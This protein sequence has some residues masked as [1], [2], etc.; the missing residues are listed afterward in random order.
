MARNY[1]YLIAGLPELSFL[2][3]DSQTLTHDFDFLNI[4]DSILEEVSAKDALHVYDLLSDI[5][6]YNLITLIYGKKRQWKN[7]GQIEEQTL[8][9]LKNR[10]LPA[11]LAAFITYIEEYENENKAKPNELAAER[12]LYELWYDKLEASKNKFIAQ[13][14]RFDREIR[15]IKAAYAGRQ[16]ETSDNRL[17]KEDDD[18]TQSLLKNT[19]PDFGLSKE[20]DYAPELFRALETDNLLEREINLDKLRWNQIDEINTFEYFTID[21]ALGVLQKARIANRW[22]ALE[23]E[24]GK[25]IFD[26]LIAG[27]KQTAENETPAT[28]L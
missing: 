7:G 3:G 4:R 26:E 13:W 6:N 27:L 28:A 21:V 1:P 19:S 15:N 12:Y 20:T 5:D 2:S 10:D 17:I 23:L 25:K 24:K 14:F 16:L 22:K 9:D 8:T 18:I 11:Y